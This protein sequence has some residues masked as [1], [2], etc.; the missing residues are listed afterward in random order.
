MGLSRGFPVPLGPL[1]LGPL[2]LVSLV[3]IFISLSRVLG[4]MHVCACAN[5]NH[6]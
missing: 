6:K 4:P 3:A 1:Q 2:P 5:H